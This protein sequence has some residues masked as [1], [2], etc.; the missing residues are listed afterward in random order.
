MTGRQAAI[1]RHET[2]STFK[3]QRYR[4]ELEDLS[5]RCRQ[6]E[7]RSQVLTLQRFS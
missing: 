4:E 3:E 5:L 2:Q 7:E 1:R 6:A